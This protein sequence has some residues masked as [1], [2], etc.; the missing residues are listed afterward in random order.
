VQLPGDLSEGEAP[1]SVQEPDLTIK[2]V[3]DHD[4]GRSPDS[5][6]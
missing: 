1:L 2:L 3:R 6:I 4:W 5:K